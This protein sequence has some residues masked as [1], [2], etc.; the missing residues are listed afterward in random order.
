MKLG[1]LV[2]D[3]CR[4]QLWNAPSGRHLEFRYGCH[5]GHRPT[6]TYDFI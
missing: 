2:G 1:I 5:I 3:P 6:F 4:I